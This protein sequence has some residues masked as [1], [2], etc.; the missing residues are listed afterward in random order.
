MDITSFVGRASLVLM[1]LI[2]SGCGVGYQKVNGRWSY[3]IWDEGNGRRSLDLNVDQASFTKLGH[4]DYAKDKDA[5]FYQNDPIPG[6]DPATFELLRDPIYARDASRAYVM[7]HPID[8]ADPR[9]FA[10]L[11]SPYSKDARSIYCG[12]RRMDVADTGKF[13]VLK[14]SSMWQ[15]PDDLSLPVTGFGWACDGT[16]HFYGMEKVE[17][18]DYESFRVI[19]ETNAAD[20]NRT[21]QGGFLGLQ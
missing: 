14:G 7:G 8:G 13:K 1:L 21:F 16:S 12:T 18:A 5:V 15:H 4:K 11:E 10:V 6:A 2:G 17:G 9:T 3:V 20:K 19:D